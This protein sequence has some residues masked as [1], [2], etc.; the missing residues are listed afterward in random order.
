MTRSA[1]A[2]LVLFI[3]AALSLSLSAWAA[4]RTH[5][6]A[7]FAIASRRLGAWLTAL[8]Y[9]AN[10]ASAWLL[11]FLCALAFSFG[12]A[13]IW[14]WVGMIFGAAITTLYVAPRLRTASA[15][16]GAFTLLQLV[17]AEAG[18]RMQPLVV[19][20][21][22]LIVIASLLVQ[23]GAALHLAS[24]VF[25]SDLGFAHVSGVVLS[26]T[27]VGV[28]V[29]AGGVR[30]AAGHEAAQALVYVIIALLLPAGALLALGGLEQVGIALDAVDPVWRDVFAGKQ[31]VVAFAF[32][33]GGVGLGLAMCGQL[34]ALNRFIAVRDDAALTRARWLALAVITVLSGVAL[35]GGWAANLLYGG[36]ERPEL[37]LFEIA[38]RLLP[39]WLSA[40]FVAALIAVVLAS[41]AGPLLA[42]SVSLVVDV[43]RSATS[44]AFGWM[45][46]AAVAV[47]VAAAAVG[48]YTSDALL[49]HALFAYT[50]LGAVLGPLVLVRVSGKRI[51][52]GSM[53]GAMWSGFALSLIF[54][55][56]PDSPG[57]FLERV[58]PFVAAL[59]VA[60]SGG[61]RRR[62]P[63]RADRAQ[64]TV[65]DRIPI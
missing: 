36:L 60:L 42:L 46:T 59:G 30:C 65:H 64:E 58:L 56:L 1:I 39:P 14:L 9:G 45:K 22:L 41:L 54:H 40:A 62:N 55:L 26:V 17:S 34:Q 63:D 19:R 12:L 61:E 35:L 32:A 23:I 3:L 13:A 53:L 27:V 20:S 33:A 47:S 2:L 52:P 25:T 44:A 51:R 29:F 24:H 38:N 18:D 15:G 6:A 48:L 50:T 8:G 43:R 37:A 7:D 57:D 5:N 21:A 11:M 31:A 4:R 10:A 28:G 49:E 16:Q